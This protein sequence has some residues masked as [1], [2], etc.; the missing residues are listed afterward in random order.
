MPDAPPDGHATPR[1]GD[2]EI[3]RLYDRHAAG[4]HRYAVMVLA[5]HALAEDA[6]QQV[7]AKR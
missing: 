4:L 7:F 1:A 3:A 2:E 6:V 5:D